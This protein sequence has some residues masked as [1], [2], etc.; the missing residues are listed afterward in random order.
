MSVRAGAES[1]RHA[2]TSGDGLLVGSIFGVAVGEAA[3]GAPVAVRHKPRLLSDNGPRFIADDLARY[4]GKHGM[5][6]VRGAPNHAQ[7]QGKIERWHQTLKNCILLD[8]YFMPG[9]LEAAIAAFVGHYNDHRY[10]ESLGNLSPAGFCFGRGPAIL[11]EG[12]KIKA[13][14]IQHRRLIHQ[15]QAA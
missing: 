10:H 5:D 13:K 7:T 9:E 15:R 2:V 11:A 3:S 4:L 6:H 14:T 8:N 12:E 1:L